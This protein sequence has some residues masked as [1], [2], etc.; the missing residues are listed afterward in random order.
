VIQRCASYAE[1][2]CRYLVTWFAD[3]HVLLSLAK[4]RR[5]GVLVGIAGYI[6][7]YAGGVI[8][9]SSRMLSCAD[10]RFLI[11]DVS[12]HTYHLQKKRFLKNSDQKHKLTILA[13]GNTASLALAAAA[14][15]SKTF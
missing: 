1:G 8:Y 14:L 4:G 10:Y 15:V 3:R 9:C 2:G 11:C 7:T 6:Y 13:Y 5:L 12:R